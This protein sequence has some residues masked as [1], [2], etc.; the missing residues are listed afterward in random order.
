MSRTDFII[1]LVE[2]CD[3]Q[4]Q[5]EVLLDLVKKRNSS[6]YEA[7]APLLEKF[8]EGLFPELSAPLKRF[9]QELNDLID[10]MPV[11]SNKLL[12][13]SESFNNDIYLGDCRATNKSLA[14]VVVPLREFAIFLESSDDL[15]SEI[16]PY[17]F[18]LFNALKEFDKQA[19]TLG[20]GISQFCTKYGLTAN[21]P[22]EERQMIQQQLD[23]LIQYRESVLYEA[24]ALLGIVSSEKISGL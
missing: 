6:V 5:I 8:K 19:K 4:R 17:H 11:L 15:P 20:E 22:R 1:I 23:S 12:S 9:E 10:Q 24:E 16:V 18:E 13:V 2:W 7:Y 21:Q 3:R 14:D